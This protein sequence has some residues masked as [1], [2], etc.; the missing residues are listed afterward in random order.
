[1]SSLRPRR[2]VLERMEKRMRSLEG[3]VRHR[4][5]QKPASEMRSTV[6]RD[7]IH[8][9]CV[10]VARRRTFAARRGEVGVRPPKS[11][12]ASSQAYEGMRLLIG[13]DMT[14]VDREESMKVMMRLEGRIKRRD[15]A[16]G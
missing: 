9:Y 12:R 3:I 8:D 10:C 16:W 14:V 2:Q 6:G 11:S 5:C 7:R 15:R 13:L 1:M 4:D